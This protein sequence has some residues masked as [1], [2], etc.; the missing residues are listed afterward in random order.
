MHRFMGGQK[1]L[2]ESMAPKKILIVDDEQDIRDVISGVLTCTKYEIFMAKNGGDAI[3]I[4]KSTDIELIILDVML[5]DKGGIELLGEI[6]KLSPDVLIII[7]TAYGSKDVVVE[8][9]RKGADYY[10]DKPFIVKELKSTVNHLLEIKDNKKYGDNNLICREDISNGRH[11]IQK[12]ADLMKENYGCYSLHDISNKLCM[13]PDYLSR[14]FK[15]KTGVRFREFRK[16][17]QITVAQNF[18]EHSSALSN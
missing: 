14:L 16:S 4:L 5:P 11:T 7:I 9:L 8:A 10:F 18:L 1:S 12:I 3:E 15:E 13:S 6:R 2:K 17:M